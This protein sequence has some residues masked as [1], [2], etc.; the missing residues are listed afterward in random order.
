MLKSLDFQERMGL[1]TR[2]I[3][4]ASSDLWHFMLLF[5][6]VL[7]GYSVV[8]HMLFG[9]QYEASR[10]GMK[11]MSTTCLTLLIFLLSLDTTQF[12]ASMSHAAPDGAFH[13]FLWSYLFIAFFILLNVFLAILVD[14]YAK[15]K[16]ETEGTTGLVEDLLETVWH[17][18]RQV[19]RTQ[20]FVSNQM[21]EQA[22]IRERETLTSKES[23]RR[24]RCCDLRE[25]EEKT[26]HVI[27]DLEDLAEENAVEVLPADGQLM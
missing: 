2:T 3:A 18:L 10:R 26:T 12:Y 14:S 17:G 19:L 22:L 11:D 7:Y 15:V 4:R 1:V 6:L 8:G 13:I 23:Q 9:H 21:L 27:D 20:Q 5:L 24:A 25:V 16:E